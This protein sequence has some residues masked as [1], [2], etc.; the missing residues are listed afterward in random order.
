MY[1]VCE[2]RANRFH[3]A[4]KQL[5]IATF[6]L[7]TGSGRLFHEVGTETEIARRPWVPTRR[8][9]CSR[10]RRIFAVCVF[11][12]QYFCTPDLLSGT[13][14]RTCEFLRIYFA[15]SA[16]SSIMQ[17]TQI[18][19]L[20]ITDRISDAV[21]IFIFGLFHWNEAVHKIKKKQKLNRN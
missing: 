1:S 12:T 20:R 3:H 10:W 4:E 16:Y 14:A 2:Y 19:C 15:H 8:G 17:R 11:F 6:G 5:Q 18:R 9:T 7:R 13:F 21:V